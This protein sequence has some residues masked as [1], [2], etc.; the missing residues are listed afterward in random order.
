MENNSKKKI[1]CIGLSEKKLQVIASYI[2]KYYDLVLI[3]H[4][5]DIEQL[6]TYTGISVFVINMNLSW[7]NILQLVNSLKKNELYKNIPIIGLCHKKFEKEIP[8]DLQFLMEDIILIPANMEDIL[9]RIEV[10]IKTSELIN[11]KDIKSFE[12]E[13]N[14]KKL[15]GD[16]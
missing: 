8:L 13:I 6:S 11:K 2:G 14:W 5:F 4:K 15:F 9:T 12:C 10:W 3:N 1:I 16:W 7:E